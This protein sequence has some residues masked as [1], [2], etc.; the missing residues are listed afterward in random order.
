MQ[1]CIV[2]SQ[3]KLSDCEYIDVG[4]SLSEALSLMDPGSCSFLMDAE[5]ALLDI[6]SRGQHIT[7]TGYPYVAIDNINILFEPELNFNVRALLESFAKNRNLVIKVSRRID[8]TTYF[9]FEGSREFSLDLQ[10]IS[11]IQVLKSDEK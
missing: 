5:T 6:I 10:G 3:R 1:F 8:G 11:F 7:T 2:F 9:P 4:K